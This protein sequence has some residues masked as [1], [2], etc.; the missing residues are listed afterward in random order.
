MNLDPDKYNN[1]CHLWNLTNFERFGIIPKDKIDT[2]ENND[3][4]DNDK[5]KKKRLISL[6]GLIAKI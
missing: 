6:L 3:S 2:L 5:Q 4:S 1:L